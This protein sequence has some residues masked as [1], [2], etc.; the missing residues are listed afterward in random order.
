MIALL[1]WVSFLILTICCAVAWDGTRSWVLALLM[2]ASILLLFATFGAFRR[3][4]W[5]GTPEDDVTYGELDEEIR[6]HETWREE[7]LR[8]V[9]T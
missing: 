8:R 6:A 2:T 9:I 5:V 7:R 4:T 1:R 3:S